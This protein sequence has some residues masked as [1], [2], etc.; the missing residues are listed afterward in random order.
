VDQKH[1]V[2]FSNGVDWPTCL[3]PNDPGAVGGD[4][5]AVSLDGTRMLWDF[6][7]PTPAASGVAVA[8]G[9][10]YFKTLDGNLYALNARAKDA[11]HALIAKFNVGAGFSGP[12][13]VDGLLFVGGGQGGFGITAYGLK[14]MAAATAAGHGGAAATALLSSKVL[15][16][17]DQTTAQAGALAGAFTSA[18]NLSAGDFAALIGVA[19]PS[20]AT[21]DALTT[22]FKAYAT[23]AAAG[24]AAAAQTALGKVKADLTAVFTALANPMADPATVTA[25]ETTMFGTLDTLLADELARNMTA[26]SADGKTAAA[27]L[28][29]LF[30]D[31]VCSRYGV[32]F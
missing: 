24:T 9:V 18:M 12:S 1:G 5:Y 19:A 27:N 2:Q 31:L 10:V 30:N 13:V 11:G 22:D 6:S 21:L 28:V 8:N 14:P 4:L 23:A 20:R 3:Q 16:R 26:A 29:T 15:A 17:G 25:D 7:T 32:K